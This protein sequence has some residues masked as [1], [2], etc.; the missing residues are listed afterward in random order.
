MTD[1]TE[2]LMAYA[3]GLGLP[4][5]TQQS[6]ESPNFVNPRWMID[7]EWYMDERLI[8]LWPLLSIES[9]WVAA[10]GACL[11]GKRDMELAH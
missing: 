11:A 1:P 4:C 2:Q 3:T 8:E 7:W 5:I 10:I 6:I 9:K